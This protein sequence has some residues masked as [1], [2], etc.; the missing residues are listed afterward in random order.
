MHRL[1]HLVAKVIGLVGFLIGFVYQTR[2]H[3]ENHEK[4]YWVAI[5]FAGLILYLVCWTFSEAQQVRLSK[6]RSN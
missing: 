3:E 6:S 4:A 5:C 2:I 1:L